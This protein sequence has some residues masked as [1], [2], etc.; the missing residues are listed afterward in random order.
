ML[1]EKS[2]AENDDV[3]CNTKS[4]SI[5]IVI[6]DN[7]VAMVCRWVVD[8][9]PQTGDRLDDIQALHRTRHYVTGQGNKTAMCVTL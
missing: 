4:H 9:A 2:R 3:F 6:L 5:W 1:R 8:D 7:W